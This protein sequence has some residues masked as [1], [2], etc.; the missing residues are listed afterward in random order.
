MKN[1]PQLQLEC[2]RYAKIAGAKLSDQTTLLD[3]QF[4]FPAASFRLPA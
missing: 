2:N 1:E 3:F 4:C